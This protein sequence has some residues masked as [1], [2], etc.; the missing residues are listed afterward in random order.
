[1]YTQQ[2]LLHRQSSDVEKSLVTF[3]D[4]CKLDKRGEYWAGQAIGSAFLGSKYG[5]E[6]RH[7]WTLEN[8]ELLKAIADD[9]ISQSCHWEGADEPWQFLQLCLEWNRVVLT[10]EKHLWDVPIGADASASGLQVLSAMRRDEKGMEWSNLFSAESPSDPPKDAYREVLRIARELARKNE[11][12]QWMVQYLT[13]RNLG[14]AILMKK[15]YGASLQT[16]RTDV[17]LALIDD[18]YYP[19]PFNYKD[20]NKL[21]TLLTVASELVFPKAFEALSWIQKLY[22]EA[23]KNGSSS[24]TWTTPNEESIHL[25]ENKFK[26]IDVRTSHLGVYLRTP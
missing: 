20:V 18:G 15:L 1:M 24:L 14:K 17:K 12:T 2:A 13:N 16:N 5:Y 23:K 6:D 9:P 11:E 22:K 4:G 10:K 3:A 21:T 8:K 26:Y 7:R 25:I 19:D